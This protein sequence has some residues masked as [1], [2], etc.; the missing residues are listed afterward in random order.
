MTKNKKK[1]EREEAIKSKTGAR[2]KSNQKGE[3]MKVKF[4]AI[5][6]TNTGFGIRDLLQKSTIKAKFRPLGLNRD[7]FGTIFGPFRDF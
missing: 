7:F 2:R 6:G 1:K 4:I 5:S 3:E